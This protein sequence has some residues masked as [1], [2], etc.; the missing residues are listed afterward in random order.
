MVDLSVELLT[1]RDSA[2]L[3]LMKLHKY[4]V[5]TNCFVLLFFIIQY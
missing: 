1:P 2:V 3:R 5:G 4:S